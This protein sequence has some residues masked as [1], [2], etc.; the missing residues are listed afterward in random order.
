LSIPRPNRHS[1]LEPLSKLDLLRML[2]ALHHE[3]RVGDLDPNENED[4]LGYR[5]AAR[6][7]RALY[8][9]HRVE[10]IARAA[11]IADGQYQ[12]RQSSNLP[13]EVIV[14]CDPDRRVRAEAQALLDRWH[15]RRRALGLEHEDDW[16]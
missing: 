14:A 5:V 10:L 2:S 9:E 6:K 11:E 12:R 3:H 4:E 15:R 1:L 8:A 7:A 13:A 16:Q